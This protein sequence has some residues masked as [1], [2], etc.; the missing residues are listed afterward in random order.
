MKTICSL[1]FQS[2]K[3][4][5]LC[6]VLGLV[7]G[8]ASLVRAGD[9]VPLVR[10][11]YAPSIQS[12]SGLFPFSHTTTFT[13]QAPVNVVAGS[14]V[15]VTFSISISSVAGVPTL[16]AGAIPATAL[17][18]VSVSPA[19]PVFTAP[20]QVQTIS[21]TVT[22]PANTVAG[23]YGYKILAN[24]FSPNPGGTIENLGT[25]LNATVSD[26]STASP[27]PTVVITTPASGETIALA[28]GATF[29][30]SIPFSFTATAG[31]TNPSPISSVAANLSNGSPVTVATV[32]GLNTA[33]VSVT[34]SMSVPGPGTYS[35]TAAA[36]N[37]SGTATTAHAFT[38][39]VPA[40]P[41]VVV[42]TIPSGD[43]DYTWFVGTP[44]LEV[45]NNFAGTT[46]A[47]TTIKSFA[48]E[49]LLPGSAAPQ[50]LTV[51][52][53]V[54]L[55]TASASATS[56]LNFFAPV[57][58]QYT[59]RV[60][61]RNKYATSTPA[62]ATF[63]V[64][65]VTAPVDVTKDA[66][67]GATFSVAATGGVKPGLAYQWERQAAGA[68]SIWV[69]LSN[70]GTYSGTSTAT[71]SIARTVLPMS[72]DKF[73]CKVGAS[74][75]SMT[76]SPAA[77]LTV[78]KRPLTVTAQNASR[79][80]GA[81]N[82]TFTA[83]VTGQFSGEA[84]EILGAAAVTSSDA[85]ATPVGG[86][87]IVPRIGTLKAVNYSFIFVNGALTITPKPITVTA[88]NKTKVYGGSDPALTY[89]V[90]V[91]TPL[92]LNDILSG[93][94]ARVAGQNVVPGG[95][96]INQGTLTSAAN[97]NY[98]I[99]FNSG[100]FTITK[101]L[102]T[103]KADDRTKVQGEANPN[104][105]A[106]M[107]GLVNGDLSTVVTGLAFVINATAASPVGTY[108][109]TVSG[110]TAANYTIS[111]LPGILT[112]TSA[113]NVS[114]T[115]SGIVFLDMSPFNALRGT[116]E[117][118]LAG[119][120]V[121]LIQTG[122]PSRTAVTSSAGAYS[123]TAVGAGSYVIDV[124]EPAGLT[125]TDSVERTVVV[126]SASTGTQSVRDIGLGLNMCALQGMVGDGYSHGYW[127]NNL[128]KA[129]AGKTGG[130]QETKTNLTAYTNTIS[131]LYLSPFYGMTMPNA[132]SVMSGS[133]QLALQLLASE[134]NYV[135][136][137]LI[138]RSQPLT[139]AFIAWGEFALKNSTS[140]SYKTYVKNWMDAFNNSHGG[141][142]SG[143]SA[144]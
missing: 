26:R 43:P 138:N 101:A 114:V 55:G 78:I 49:L 105:T 74:L 2:S 7:L 99:T 5:L 38:V 90:S 24:G 115:I 25:F 51:S 4:F 107:T 6:S 95:Y 20:N 102:L 103:V 23:E 142:F 64:N 32:D 69:A 62:T 1:A 88:E 75:A 133:D 129:I 65:R 35:L 11:N 72:G 70:D 94:L 21:V 127:K 79:V 139:F 63:W 77:T 57:S 18:Y 13:V 15:P 134:Y 92:V 81:A 76:A 34:G 113:T 60:T 140:S 87:A 36:T 10:G 37:G 68:G 59:L 39:T 144:P 137:R 135:S 40:V 45:A 109:I 9:P 120:T 28:A 122:Q 111:Y 100:T 96:A 71:L 33:A 85:Q 61:A 12:V 73:R 8:G 44:T 46:A 106:S 86:Y 110:G 132:V 131:T 121:K 126:T 14:S 56:L 128:S 93:G 104:P 48:A 27:A 130:T 58:G 42:I 19:N 91:N 22:I 89:T 53:P 108:S 143:P 83:V 136:G 117:P 17:S 47:G 3:A 97:P 119:I 124:Q 123:F 98:M 82:P 112:V 67:L 84:A 52:S 29:P 125:P 54:G 66:F 41:P 80:Y 16:P 118:L 30:A 31:G 116:D 141:P 50:A